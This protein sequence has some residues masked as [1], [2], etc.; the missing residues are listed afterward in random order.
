MLRRVGGAAAV[1]ERIAGNPEVG[2]LVSRKVTREELCWEIW[3]FARF[4]FECQLGAL[5]VL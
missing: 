1:D 3:G 2:P 5:Q 4:C